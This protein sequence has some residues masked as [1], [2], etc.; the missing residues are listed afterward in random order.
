MTRAGAGRGALGG[1]VPASPAPPGG[2]LGRR[3]QLAQRLAHVVE[4]VRDVLERPG[5]PR[6]VAQPRALRRRLERLV[7]PGEEG[8][9]RAVPVGRIRDVLLDHR[10]GTPRLAQATIL[11]DTGATP[12]PGS[13]WPA[14]HQSNSR[15]PFGVAVGRRGYPP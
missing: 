4:L 15:D 7:G 6:R 5:D 1:S 8:G 12:P 13:P 9:G 14:S 11:P 10:A 3:R 2:G